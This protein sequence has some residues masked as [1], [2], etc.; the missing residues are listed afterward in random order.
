MISEDEWE[1]LKSKEVQALTIRLLQE[2]QHTDLKIKRL[3][4]RIYALECQKLQNYDGL[5]DG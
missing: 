4:Q 3:E 2:L 1:H 5:I